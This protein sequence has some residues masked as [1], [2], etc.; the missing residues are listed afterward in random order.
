MPSSRLLVPVALAVL[1]GASAAR[2][3]PVG[4]SYSLTL[5]GTGSA[6]T[7]VTLYGYNGAT[8]VLTLAAGGTA[9]AVPGGAVSGN[10]FGTPIT[11]AT[12]SA[13]LLPGSVPYVDVWTTVQMKLTDTASGE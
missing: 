4:F 7:S 2:A 13:D 11:V 10:P 8:G 5:G 9:S 12:V 1:L 3:D 6:N